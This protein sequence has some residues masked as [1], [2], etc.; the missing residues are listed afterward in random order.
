MDE[1]EEFRHFYCECKP[2]GKEHCEQMLQE[3]LAIL[4][5]DID[6]LLTAVVTSLNWDFQAAITHM[7]TDM[8][9]A[10]IAET[11]NGEDPFRVRIE[12]DRL[13]HGVA[14]AW[15]AF[16][17]HYPGKWRGPSPF[18]RRSADHA[19]EAKVHRRLQEALA[20]I[21]EN[22]CYGDFSEAQVKLWTALE[23]LRKAGTEV[24]EGG[25]D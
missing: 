22:E 21:A 15:K 13:E 14:G 12:C 10:V 17:E 24:S 20:T 8:W 7:P 11:H 16:H 19:L 1:P 5:V 3:V 4:K 2:E 18:P 9:S 23:E 6:Y 25:T